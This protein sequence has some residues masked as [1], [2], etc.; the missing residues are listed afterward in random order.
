MPKRKRIPTN[1][2]PKKKKR[3]KKR[4]EKQNKCK[5]KKN[6][7]DNIEENYKHTNLKDIS[8]TDE[9]CKN[10]NLN[11]IQNY[12]NLYEFNNLFLD[13]NLYR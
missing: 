9:E 2:Y 3:N 12:Q 4:S 13:N 1:S 6:H 7:K 10:K 8:K 11:I 5:E